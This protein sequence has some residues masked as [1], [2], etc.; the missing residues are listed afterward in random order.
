MD[1]EDFYRKLVRALHRCEFRFRAGDV[2]K[3]GLATDRDKLSSSVRFEMKAAAEL[4]DLVSDS[5]FSASMVDLHPVFNQEGVQRCLDEVRR[6]L[7]PL[8]RL[9]CSAASDQQ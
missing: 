5:G 9:Q 8:G 3:E 2:G 1:R 6:Y 4:V 7:P